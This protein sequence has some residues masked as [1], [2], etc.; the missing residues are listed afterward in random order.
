[1]WL[2]EILVRM[3]VVE[4]VGMSVLFEMMVL[5]SMFS[6]GRWLLFISILV[7]LSCS[8][9]I[10]CCMVSIVVCRMLR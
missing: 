2:C 5:V 3:E 6:V 7:G 10:V 8:F 1:M 9:C 4:I